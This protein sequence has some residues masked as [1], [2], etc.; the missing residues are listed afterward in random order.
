[1]PLLSRVVI[2]SSGRNADRFPRADDF[3]TDVSHLDLDDV[4]EIRLV[5]VSIPFPEPHVARGRDLLHIDG[6]KDGPGAAC[7]LTRGSYSNAA[8]LARELTLS[9]RRDMGPGFSANTTRLG[10]I[11]IEAFVPFTLRTTAAAKARDALGFPESVPLPGSAATVLG[12]A[13]SGADQPALPAGNRYLAL[14]ENAPLA[15]SDEV[16][17][18]RI[19]DVCGVKSQ[20]PAFDR[21]F[22][23]LHNGHAADP[24]PCVHAYDPPRTTIKTLRIRLVRRDGQPFDT[25]GRDLTLHL[26]VVKGKPYR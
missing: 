21:A 5:Y 22:A 11:A 20:T 1:M 3:E 26:D 9:L 25:D 14:A 10:R 7:R 2:D 23:V 19:S 8:Q 15:R 24:L 17:I 16:A 4:M 13:V 6:G 18:L 12:F